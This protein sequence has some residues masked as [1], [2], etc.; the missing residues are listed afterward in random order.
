MRDRFL[1]SVA[2]GAIAAVTAGTVVVLLSTQTS[3]Q[4]PTASITTLKTPWGEP[5]L[6]GIWT[7]EFDTEENR[8][9]SEPRCLEGNYG[10]PGLLHGRRTEEVLFA[11]GR[12][13]HPAT[14]DNTG[15]LMDAEVPQD[16]LQQ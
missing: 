7:D 12:S 14:R 8:I 6:Q 13:P 5:D 16:P 11:G 15:A 10:L 9:Y 2:T 4:G 3:A 1:N